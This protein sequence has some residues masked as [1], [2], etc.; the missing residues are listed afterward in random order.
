MKIIDQIQSVVGSEATPCVAT[1]GFFDGVHRGHRCLIRQVTDEAACRGL[2]SLLV[3]FANH[4]AC[5]LRPEAKLE[6]LTTAE[7]KQA[8]LTETGVDAVAMLPFTL[9]LA[10][11]SARDFMDAVLK[12]RFAVK[13][14]VIGYDHRFG[15]RSA[16]EHFSDYVRYGREL[17]IDVVQASELE[18]TD[19]V[20]SSLIRH[21]LQTGD[22]ALANACLGYDYFM[23][24][25]VVKGFHVGRTIGFPTANLSL[26]SEK[27]VPQRGV[28]AVDVE[29]EGLRRRG[30]L[31]IG[32]RPTVEN[33]SDVSIEVNIFDFH[34]DIYSQRVRV[35]LLKFI[36][37]EKKFATVDELRNQLLLDERTCRLLS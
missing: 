17:G 2:Q 7:E 35:H 24:G 1:I 21:A 29:V 20:S 30:M 19:H 37:N 6:L 10:S 28:Y 12:Q 27:L 33:G 14:L 23:E 25:P 26:A 8:L 4:P 22:V 5:V 36:R 16:G 15:R 9:E 18:G 11:L 32:T 13:V 3:T 31:N 34:H